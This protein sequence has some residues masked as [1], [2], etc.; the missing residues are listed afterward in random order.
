MT[1][2]L[3]FDNR[4]EPLLDHLIDFL[5]APASAGAASDPFARDVLVTASLGLGRWLQQG[6]ARRLGIASAVELQLPSRFLWHMMSRLLEDVSSDSPFEPEVVRWIIY[7]LLA[8][9]AATPELEPQRLAVLH[10]R[11]D[12][13]AGAAVV[14]SQELLVLATQIAREFAQ[15]LNFRRDWLERWAQGKRVEIAPSEAGFAR[16]EAWL[17]W[18]W[19]QTL[20]RMPTVSA[21]HP[22]DRFKQWL[23]QSDATERGERFAA[24]GIRRIAV[25]GLPPMSPEQIDLFGRLS[26]SIDVAF[27][28][29]DPSR[30]FWQDLV[31]PRYLAE[32][33]NSR[34]D[35]AWLYDSEP[36]VLGSWGR[37]Q[38]DYLAQLRGLEEAVRDRSTVRVVEDFRDQETLPPSSRLQA[39]QQSLL[40][41]SN[42]AWRSLAGASSEYLADDRS[43]QI[44]ACHGTTRQLEVL[45]DTLLQAF[46]SMPDLKPEQ[47][48][49][50]APDIEL[51]A[52][53]IDGV[54]GA[55]QIP[56]SIEGRQLQSDSLT[57]AFKAL[58]RAASS[59]VSSL[60]IRA[61]LE[62]PAIAAALALDA[63]Q[64]GLLSDWLERAGFRYVTEDRDGKHDWQAAIERLWLGLCTATEDIQDPAVLADRIAVAGLTPTNLDQLGKLEFLFN[65]LTRLSQ[66]DRSRP[67]VRQWCGIAAH[68]VERWFESTAASAA[69]LLLLDALQAL[70]AQAARAGNDDQASAARL[71][72][73][74]FVRL[75]DEVQPAAQSAV[76]PGSAMS[77]SSIDALGAVPARV[78]AW[79]GMSDRAFPRHK[80]ALEFDLIQ[81]QP[82]FGDA[83]PAIIDR[84]A[85]LQA[86]GLS[87]D[88]F[89]LLFDGHDLR[90]NEALNPSLLVDELLAYVQAQVGQSDF[91]VIE[92]SLL[93]FSPQVFADPRRPGYDSLAFQA[94]QRLRGLACPAVTP[95]ADGSVPTLLPI[96]PPTV[97]PAG[98]KAYLPANAPAVIRPETS[99]R[100]WVTVLAK[101]ALAYLR[102][103][104]GLELP[105]TYLEVSSDPPLDPFDDLGSNFK[106]RAQAV[107]DL[108]LNHQTRTPFKE[109]WRLQPYLPQ[110]AMGELAIQRFQA[111]RD[112]RWSA[113]A[114]R[115]NLRPD[116]QESNCSLLTRSHRW[117]GATL[118]TA[119]LDVDHLLATEYRAQIA[120]TAFAEGAYAAIDTWIRHQVA[121]LVYPEERVVSYW[122]GEKS[123]W[124]ID[125]A[126]H[127]ASSV[128]AEAK[129]SALVQWVERIKCEP[130]SLFP[131]TYFAWVRA[132]QGE[133]LDLNL[134][135]AM[136]QT[137]VQKATEQAFE[138]EQQDRSHVALYLKGTPELL[139]ALQ[140]SEQVYRVVFE[141]LQ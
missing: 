124:Q 51:F 61:L 48:R 107:L 99:Q 26:D 38:R 55:G 40:F 31:S 98:L 119:L 1:L 131:K 88:R 34:P 85:F 87:S 29:P 84:G 83:S 76:R 106:Q 91:A 90:S 16:H 5:A 43:L 133:G 103:G 21:R 47:V 20:L 89:I 109:L 2:S 80:P 27:F 39:L 125:S 52:D 50:L 81:A 10:G 95:S 132:R 134:H 14:S 28:V 32:I 71:S 72:L 35:L 9:I 75:L 67:T 19:Q 113:T 110:A 53:A 4:C 18:L 23:L 70:A 139:A 17:S 100:D 41:L 65:A 54:F 6:I 104:L 62:E 112:A 115:L 60:V 93:R 46:D 45:R 13:H 42:E 102:H 101:P 121:C 111:L 33:R 130:L 68:E 30:E 116:L 137:K 140:A 126:A 22:Y 49:V 63:V 57:Q 7:P 114:Q 69:R 141:S 118:Q 86:I 97:A 129:L 82:R 77:F 122:F 59:P 24:S 108:P 12:R 37:M 120:W 79:L 105:R 73:G 66:H 94:A 127:D 44:H 64:A 8:E 11:F 136:N 138:R 25:F 123:A 78:T 15:L 74:A 128:S 92:Q 96:V 117:H 135:D 3:Y 58:L 36:V 56:Y